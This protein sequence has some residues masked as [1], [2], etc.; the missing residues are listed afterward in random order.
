TPFEGAS[1]GLSFTPE[2]REI[3]LQTQNDGS[4]K[5]FNFDTGRVVRRP[6]KVWWPF[7]LTADG[8]RAISSTGGLSTG[9]LKVWDRQTGRE[10]RTLGKGSG[11]REATISPDGTKVLLSSG[12][13]LSLLD[14]DTGRVLGTPIKL[15]TEVH[16]LAFSPDG[17]QAIAGGE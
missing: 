6:G 2:G 13:L 16:S 4:L 10:I 8:Q 15:V 12:G 9:D 11:A 14:F 1:R 3:Y 17:R 7:V 5:V